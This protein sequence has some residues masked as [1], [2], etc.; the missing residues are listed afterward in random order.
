MFGVYGAGVNAL[1]RTAIGGVRLD[2]GLAPG[3]F[4]PLTPEERRLLART[5]TP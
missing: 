2:E 5:Q 3:D 4:R 1:H